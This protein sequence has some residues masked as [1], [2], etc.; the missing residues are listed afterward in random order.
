MSTLTA[1]D[2][3]LTRPRKPRRARLG[4]YAD[5][6][7]GEARELVTLRGAGGSTLVIDRLAWTHSDARLVAHLAADESPENAH[8]ICEM[9]LADE[10]RGRCRRVTIQDF[11]QHPPIL[12]RPTARA[13]PS[14]SDIPLLD[15]GGDSYLIRAVLDE[16]RGPVLRWTRTHQHG[17]E[18]DFSVLTLRDVV[19]ALEEYEPARA[20][21]I[22]ALAS[23]DGQDC[24]SVCQLRAELERLDES[25]IL[26]NRGLR[27]LVQRE[28]ARGEVSLSEIARRCGRLKRDHRGN[29]SGDT[30][31]LGRRIGLMP[32]G[33]ETTP[34]PW[35]HSDTLALIA[36]DGLGVC[37]REIELG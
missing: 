23:L 5:P 10:T 36:R 16:N 14:P 37:P 3:Q 35:I 7:G 34:T 25:S 13:T 6:N 8:L 27:E 11:E 26:L 22:N 2:P 32:E 15:A 12:T 24:S 19:G 33:G 18:D 9:Y 30:S 31:W 1:P 20:L 4:R 17:F 21:T 28:V 29:L